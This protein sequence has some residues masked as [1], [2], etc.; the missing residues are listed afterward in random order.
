MPTTPMFVNYL[1]GAMDGAAAETHATFTALFI[2]EPGRANSGAPIFSGSIDWHSSVH[3]HLAMVIDLESAGD[4]DG[5]ADF[6]ATRFAADLVQGEIDLSFYDPYGWAWLLRLD[7]RL[8]DNGHTALTPLAEHLGEA[9]MALIETRFA[10]DTMDRGLGSYNDLN[11]MM[12]S[13]A[14]WSEANGATGMRRRLQ[15]IFEANAP[16]I[17]TE[18]GIREGDFFSQVG[19]A[20]QAHVT[21]GTTD[22]AAYRALY[23]TMLASVTDGSLDALIADTQ[24]NAE[25]GLG[26]GHFAG[27][28]LSAAYGYWSLFEETLEPA[29]YAAYDRIVHFAEAYAD[30]LGDGIGPGHWL[31]N[32]AAFATGLPAEAPVADPTGSIAAS[33]EAW[34]QAND[35]NTHQHL[36]GST[37]DDTL[38]GGYGEDVLDGGRGADVLEGGR[39][40]DTLKAGYDRGDGDVFDGGEGVDTYVIDGTEVDNFRFDVNLSTGTDRYNNTY[41]DIENVVGGRSSDTLTGNREDNILEGRDGNDRLDGGRGADQLFGGNGNDVL[42]A[43]YDRGDGDLFDGGN[44]IDTYMIAGTEVDHFAF[45]VSLATGTDRYGNRYV[46]IENVIGGTRND[47]LTGDAGRNKLEGRAGDDTLEGGGGNDLLKGGSGF[48]TAVFNG[49]LDDFVFSVQHNGLIVTGEGRD[50]LRDDI[51]RLVF[52]DTTLSYAEAVALADVSV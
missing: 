36:L 35:Y 49:L 26:F 48:D 15:E 51:E 29:F 38:V 47:A 31:P 46:D 20:A 27:R 14:E 52:D 23:D 37:G 24:A 39:G 18:T 16:Q 50:R 30:L 4:T 21:F 17:G 19:I 13:L 10:D 45:D 22:S 28:V 44:G 40:N 43:G 6:V 8:Q 9:L 41:I 11:W 12:S 42:L 34:L 2:D 3:A 32:F 25:A 33:I 1:E 7:M 5:L